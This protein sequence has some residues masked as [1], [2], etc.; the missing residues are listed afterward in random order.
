MGELNG[1]GLDSD[2]DEMVSFSLDKRAA[3]TGLSHMMDRV[4]VH[5]SVEMKL[6]EKWHEQDKERGVDQQKRPAA[7]EDFDEAPVSGEELIN[8]LKKE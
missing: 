4:N 8:R 7:K 1:H 3:L 2:D 6:M 5:L